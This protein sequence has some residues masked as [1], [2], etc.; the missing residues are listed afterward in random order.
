LGNL[1]LHMET[2][3]CQDSYAQD[4]FDLVDNYLL[5]AVRHTT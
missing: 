3:D 5:E 4:L 2:T 1:L